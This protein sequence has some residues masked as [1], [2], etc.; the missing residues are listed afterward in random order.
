MAVLTTAEILAQPLIDGTAD[1][2]YGG[3][4][5]T[6]NTRTQFG[7]GPTGGNPDPIITGTDFAS[8][9][10]S[11]LDQVFA[12]IA[13]DRLYVTISGNL[14]ENFNKLDV[15]I[16][17]KSGGVNQ[18][19]GASL[20][21]GLDGFCCGG[22]TPPKGGNT[23]NVGALQQ[24]NGM[25]F[26]TGFDADYML[27]FTHG[28][29]STGPTHGD[30][31]SNG[32]FDAADYTVWRDKLGQPVANLDNR[33]SNTGVIDQAE[34]DTWK[35]NFGSNAKSEFWALSA[36]FAE[37]GNGT[38]GVAGALGYQLAPRGE[39]RVLRD[40]GTG[41]LG[42]FS[43]KP[44][45]NPGNT[46]TLLSSFTLDGLAQGQLIDRDYAL[47]AGGCDDDGGTGCLAREFEFALD[48]DPMENG[49]ENPNNSN[50]R[51][52]NN[53]VDLEMA[54]NNSNIEGVRGSGGP[55]DLVEEEDN[56]QD[57]RTGIE[58]SIP[59]SAIGDPTGSIRIA[60]MINGGSHN[61]LS[62][63]IAGEGIVNFD[64]PG[65]GG[66]LGNVFFGDTPLGSFNDLPGNQY[67]T[68]SPIL[69][70][71]GSIAAVPEPATLLLGIVSFV[72]GGLLFRRR[73]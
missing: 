51:N 49:V 52:F 27:I 47:S 28:G 39:P 4:L 63:Q 36:H 40:G 73:M 16:D 17:S 22:L 61:F 7:D 71:G 59:L 14:E 43:Y 32:S 8:G 45:G 72:G 62:N 58:F 70:G 38:A 11:E 55:F 64:G 37:L 9:G 53:F 23:N 60:V 3:A 68:V 1:V 54:I 5:S 12:T 41:A 50:H 56:P 48:V 19:N 34:Y 25:Q 35:A 44:S 67:V 33:P 65:T 10:G 42:D 26:D 20:P 21:G 24:M 30:Y 31:N 18:L 15:F 29:E 2:A 46:D 13:N 69:E 6:Q 66:N 57:V